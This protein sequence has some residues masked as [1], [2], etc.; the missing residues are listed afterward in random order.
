MS[1]K[2][3]DIDLNA[4]VVSAERSDEAHRVNKLEPIGSEAETLAL[5]EVGVGRVDEGLDI[6]NSGEA[7]MGHVDEKMDDM[8]VGG[9]IGVDKGAID[10]GLNCN[11]PNTDI[12]VGDSIRLEKNEGVGKNF[13]TFSEEKVVDR[14]GESVS[15]RDGVEGEVVTSC[16]EEGD[17]Q[18]TDLHTVE[19]VGESVNLDVFS[20]DTSPI[21]PAVASGSSSHGGAEHDSS[22]D[23]KCADELPD[24]SSHLVTT[25]WDRKFISGIG[26]EGTEVKGE[27]GVEPR[28]ADDT[29]PHINGF[30]SNGNEGVFIEMQTEDILQPQDTEKENI[31]RVALKPECD[32]KESQTEKEGQFHVSD[33]VW[34]KV[35]SHPWWPGQIFGASDASEKA[36]KYCKKDSF[37]VAYFGDQTFAWNDASLIKPFRTHFSQMEKQSSTEAFRHA[38]D[39]ALE[40]VSRRVEFGLAC[41]C[42]TGEM[43]DK[44][45]TQIIVNAGIHE[46][47]SRRDGGDEYSSAASFMPVNT[48]QYLKALAQSPYSGVDRLEF[49]IARAQLL[50]FNHWKG[51]CQ[52]PE[53]KMLDGLLE[54]GADIPVIG[55]RKYSEGITEDA[56]CVPSGKKQFPLGKGKGKL[57]IQDTS[58]RKRREISSDGVSSSKKERR[59]SDLMSRSP[60]NLSNCKDEPDRKAG[61]NLSSP[62]SVKK[63]K[64]DDSVPDESR[65][66]NKKVS[67]S[68]VTKKQFSRVGE[69]I[70]KVA[71]QLAMST[72]ILKAGYKK[73]LS[74]N[75]SNKGLS[76]TKSDKSQRRKGIPPEYPP[77]AEMLLQLHVAAR[78]HTKGYNSL[79]S[80]VSFFSDF[81]NS[82]CQENSTS[83]EHKKST[84]KVFCKQ[85]GK[86]LS[87]PETTETSGFEGM[88]DSYWTDR[89]VQSN[90]EEQVLFEPETPNEKGSPTIEPEAALE[91]SAKS[92]SKQESAVGDCELDGETTG[93]VDEKND[94]AYTPTALILNFTDLDSLPSESNLNNIFRHYGP[95]NESD[96]E[97]LKKSR[98]A[99]VI[100]KR[101]SDAETAFSSTGK[102]STFGPSLVSYRLNY[103]PSTQRKTSTSPTKQSRKSSTSGDCNAA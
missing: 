71:S 60:S 80:N 41:S 13:S 51:F 5:G 59:M 31:K 38:V 33:L 96:T 40:E 24:R 52:L 54:D 14:I 83:R 85:T 30:G 77:P 67:L 19:G 37:L 20:E 97:V 90:N 28:L 36:R 93:C 74:K 2:L 21:V 89:I 72:P 66:K 32:V 81:R 9:E 42:L 68:P 8:S 64:A 57:V 18:G 11:V 95:L 47:A 65:V 78:D 49:A 55:E 103:L 27:T 16:G 91:S 39:R 25:D 99:K 100:F 35:R 88:E 46:E 53:F 45:K 76:R 92:N 62:S 73:T 82:F 79:K 10:L 23:L 22:R 86:K 17:D 75:G 69:S 61:R 94:E 98:R 34:G 26:N 56:I 102:F 12:Y 70:R 101:R 43:H 3:D 58:S 84:G 7:E 1:V 29:T 48:V 50:A 15:G 6:E 87:Y 44:I 63:R 4:D